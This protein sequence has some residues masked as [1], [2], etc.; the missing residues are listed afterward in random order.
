[1][2]F[3]LLQDDVRRYLEENVWHKKDGQ[4]YVVLR[5]TRGNFQIFSKA[6]D[7]GIRNVRPVSQL[8]ISHDI[9]KLSVFCCGVLPVQEG[10]Q[11]QDT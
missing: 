11:V 7:D 6:K 10:E 2:G 5:R 9:S 3:E 1:V 4:C 8:S